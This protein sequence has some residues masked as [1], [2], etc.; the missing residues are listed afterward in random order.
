MINIGDMKGAFVA[1]CVICAFVGWASIEFA[2]WL[3]SFVSISLGLMNHES[4]TINRN[5]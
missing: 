2:L 4:K 5:S 3:L 1:I